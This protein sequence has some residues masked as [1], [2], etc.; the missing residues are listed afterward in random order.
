[1]AAFGNACMPRTALT[2]VAVRVRAD[3]G[4]CVEIIPWQERVVAD[5][6]EHCGELCILRLGVFGVDEW[7]APTHSRRLRAIQAQMTRRIGRWWPKA[8]EDWPTSSR[9][10][11][12]WAQSVEAGRDPRVGH[13]YHRILALGWTCSVSRREGATKV[14]LPWWRDA[15]WRHTLRMVHAG[16]DGRATRLHRGHRCLGRRR[17]DDPLQAT[18]AVRAEMRWQEYALDRDA[19][20]GLEQ[21][22]VARVLRR[23][24]AGLPE[25]PHGRHVTHTSPDSL[26]APGL[27]N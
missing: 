3:S 17:R 15:W 14:V 2:H 22:F 19:R 23:Q 11:S 25:V 27:R 6:R 5:A 16:Q 24:Q 26:H 21:A 12:E 4:D 8:C 7:P 20:R 18:V 10:C 13:R 9:R 1:M